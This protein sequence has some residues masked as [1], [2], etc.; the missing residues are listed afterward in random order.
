M[1]TIDSM[2]YD[3]RIFIQLIEKIRGLNSHKLNRHLNLYKKFDQLKKSV[4]R[5]RDGFQRTQIYQPDISYYDEK[6]KINWEI[7]RQFISVDFEKFLK[8]EFPKLNDNEIRLCC[9]LFLKI[10]NKTIA[11]I[12]PFKTNSIYPT[13]RRIRQKT[14]VKDLNELFQLIAFKWLATSI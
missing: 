1:E 9:L 7:I 6:G 5:E 3:K 10:K 8:E 11:Q 2:Q 4:Q 12:L 13:I 14:D